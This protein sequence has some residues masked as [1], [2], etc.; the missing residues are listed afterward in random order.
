MKSREKR[1][2]SGRYYGTIR[3]IKTDVLVN[4]AK[5]KNGK[6]GYAKYLK[7]RLDTI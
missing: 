6:N 4:L 1:N 7:I 5:L 2:T 3:Y